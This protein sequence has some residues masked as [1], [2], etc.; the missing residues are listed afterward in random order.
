MQNQS[1]PWLLARTLVPAIRHCEKFSYTGPVV[2]NIL[3]KALWQS[4]GKHTNEIASSP[5]DLCRIKVYAGSSQGREYPRSV[6]AKSFRVQGWQLK[7]SSRKLCGNLINTKFIYRQKNRSLIS[8][9][10]ITGMYDNN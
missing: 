4:I 6:L 7:T 9:F 5:E 2:K 3:R 8:I 10:I 1:L